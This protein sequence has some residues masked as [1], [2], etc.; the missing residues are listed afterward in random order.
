MA[1]T[2]YT[3]GLLI[4]QFNKKCGIPNCEMVSGINIYK[5]FMPSRN[6]G[7]DTT[8]YLTVPEGYFAFN[9]MH[10]GRDEKIPVALND[11]GKDIVVSS[12][13]FVFKVIDE[14]IIKNEYLNIIMKSHE[15]D[16]YAWFCTDSSVR[17]NLDWKRF[18]EI[19]INLPPI[20]VQEQF[21]AVYTA[22]KANQEAYERGLANLEMALAASIEQFKHTESRI[23]VGTLLEEVDSRNRDGR[24][25]DTQGI[26]INKDFMPSVANLETTD[27]TNYKIISKDKFAYSPMQTGRDECIRIA[28]Y[29]EDEPAI[30]SP[31]YS[32]LQVK[33]TAALA[34]YIMLWFSR[35]ESDRY[36]WFISDSSIRA[37]LELPRFYEIEIPL[38]SLE[39]QQAVVNLYNARCLIKKNINRLRNLIKDLCPILIKGSLQAA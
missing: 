34:E 23:A 18:C 27:L 31:A 4:K 20:K 33:G 24:I 22:M 15:F 11:K 9:L 8:G 37:S 19:E 29:H 28:L 5:Q 30:I 39:K 32:V 12:A 26:N 3:L 17:G 21:V 10:V 13:Y 35:K 16:R 25:I 1:L 2:K 38:P 14:K 6:V 36:G 7:A